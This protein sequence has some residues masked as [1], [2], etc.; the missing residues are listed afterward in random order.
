M[1]QDDNNKIHWLYQAKNRSRLWAIMVI[2]LLLTLL[3]EFFIHKHH[4]FV[5]QGVHID[6]SWG[7]YA[8]FAFI[9]CAFMVVLAKFM[10]IFL[11][12]KENYYDD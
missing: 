10:G 8:W 9:S 7:F 3:P 12:R 2:I 4:N 1:N 5:D 11:K 6:G